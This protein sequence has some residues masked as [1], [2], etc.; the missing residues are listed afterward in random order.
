MCEQKL[1]IMKH[2][3]ERADSS[4]KRKTPACM[5]PLKSAKRPKNLVHRWHIM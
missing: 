3:F 2:T 1:I 4:N 5:P